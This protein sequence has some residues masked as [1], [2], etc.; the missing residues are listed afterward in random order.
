MKKQLKYY[1]LSADKVS[2]D[3]YEI[4]DWHE[5]EK[6]GDE[7]PASAHE[8]MDAAKKDGM[9]L[10]VTEFM[11]EFNLEESIGSNNWIFVTSRY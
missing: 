5:A 11:N 6:N 4:M 9:V 3:A 7:L 2:T 10:S 8:F 1:V